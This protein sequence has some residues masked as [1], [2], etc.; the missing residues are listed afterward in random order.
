MRKTL[1]SLLMTLLTP[2]ALTA[3]D[4]QPII[5]LRSSTPSFTITIGGYSKDYI[6]VDAGNGQE[7]KEIE[8]TLTT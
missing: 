8:A 6:D 2:F 3:Q 4:E 5:T 1:L 7:E